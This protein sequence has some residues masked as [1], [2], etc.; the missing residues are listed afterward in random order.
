MEDT[1][2]DEPKRETGNTNLLFGACFGAMGGAMAFGAGFICP[3]CT[4]GTP[5]LLGMGAW[6]KYK[7]LKY[8]SSMPKNPEEA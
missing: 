5:L 4:I 6:Q 7:Y 1:D 2:K 8:K 3:A